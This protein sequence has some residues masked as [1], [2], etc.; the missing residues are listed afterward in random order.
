MKPT[1][2]CSITTLMTFSLSL[3]A[4]TPFSIIYTNSNNR[5]VY[6]SDFD[7]NHILD[8]SHAGYKGGG[9]A[10]PDIQGL[11]VLNVPN[12]SDP[13]CTN[14]LNTSNDATQ[15]IQNAINTVSNYVADPNTGLRGV[16]QLA[17]GNYTLVS[18]WTVSTP[19]RALLSIPVSGVVVNGAGSANTTLTVSGTTPVSSGDLAVIMLG[20]TNT[21]T[22]YWRN[23]VTSSTAEIAN[24]YIPAGSTEFRVKSGDYM[25]MVGDNIIIN[26]PT[27][28]YW[29]AYQ[30]YGG[31]NLPPWQSSPLQKVWGDGINPITIN[32]VSFS[33]LGVS[34]V[35]YNR[36]ITAV[37]TNTDGTYGLSIDTPIY[38]AINNTDTNVNDEKPYIYPFD[39]VSAG[40][41]NEIGV[42]GLNIVIP[43]SDGSTDGTNKELATQGIYLNEAEDIWINDV[44]VS[45]YRTSAFKTD[46][47]HQATISNCTAINN[48]PNLLNT[49]SYGYGFFTHNASNNILFS[50][51]SAVQPRHA[52]ITSEPSSSDIVYLN[53]VSD[54]NLYGSEGHMYW[55]QGV[56]FDHLTMTH[57]KANGGTADF[58]NV[59]EGGGG[60]HGWGAVNSVMWGMNFDSSSVVTLQQPPNGQN[61]CMNC[62]SANILTGQ[63]ISDVNG[64]L[65]AGAPGYFETNATIPNTSLASLYTSQLAERQAAGGLPPSAPAKLTAVFSS[66]PNKVTLAWD[67]LMG[68]GQGVSGFG[69]ERSNDGGLTWTVLT[70]GVA[71]NATSFVDTSGTV[72]SLYRIYANKLLGAATVQSAY[73]NMAPLVARY[74]KMEMHTTSQQLD[75][76]YVDLANFAVYNRSV[77]PAKYTLSTVYLYNN[78]TNTYA[79]NAIG[80]CKSNNISCG[81]DS[82]LTTY[83]HGLLASPW[84]DHRPSTNQRNFYV[85]LG[86][87]KAIGKISVTTG[88]GS[89]YYSPEYYIYV[90]RDAVKWIRVYGTQLGTRTTN[91]IIF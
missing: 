33:T 15:C 62:S 10:L 38:A 69:V 86:A 2:I 88:V 70:T 16:V 46:N 58:M 3:Y 19:L 11:P 21:A 4:V 17:A 42:Q 37:V 82:S 76:G 45:G 78:T 77:T 52:F 14:V 24:A 22:T 68:P 55:S 39:S 47:I 8:F 74:V 79:A 9:V 91:N 44:I 41:Q 18:P 61:Y 59:G 1:Q 53:S 6:T 80:T 60:S 73:S 50:S 51:D 28:N 32:G 31:I 57:T 23:L 29:S 49:G 72:N 84:I 90:S 81:F 54:N 67:N 56:L 13:A 7:G 65:A 87:P 20:G 30:S 35:L 36:K 5:Y 43:S 66:S 75:G 34:P 27:N 89:T 12:A 40:Y 64:H 48:N 63:S 83:Y 25:P 85:D 26:V 71:A